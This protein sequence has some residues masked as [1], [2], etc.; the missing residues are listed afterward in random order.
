MY[1]YLYC[2]VLV[3]AIICIGFEVA[4]V[5]TAYSD[6]T[7]MEIKPI[8]AIYDG[9]NGFAL[10]DGAEDIVVYEMGNRTYAFV[11]SWN[12][13]G[14][15]IID[16]TNPAAPTAVAAISDGVNGFTELNDARNIV[17]SEIGNR[18]YAFVS[19]FNDDGVQIIDVT[20][21]A[22]PTAVAAIS[23]G[24]NGFTEL[25]GASDLTISEIGNRTYALVTGRNDD[26]VQII[27]VTNPA[28]PT[29]VAAISDGVNGFTELNG[30]ID[31]VISVIGNTTYAFVASSHGDGVQIIDVTNPAAPTAVAA[32]S[33]GVNGFTEL[34]AVTDIV[35]YE[36]GNHTYA[37]VTSWDDDGVQII[38]VTN[39]AAPTAVAAIS[40][41]VNGFTELDASAGITV[42]PIGN[43]TYAFVTGF[44]DDGVQIIDV[45]NP[46]APTAVAAIS[47]GVN[48]FTELDGATDITL[49][50]IGNRTYAFVACWESAS[51]Q[52]IDVTNPA[53]PVLT[54][55]VS[56]NTGGFAALDAANGVA[57]T[58]IH[59]HTYAVVASYS[60]DGVQIINITNP[61]S[62]T[63]TA[64]VTDNVG[65]FTE[66]D[67]AHEVAITKMSDQTYAIVASWD[68]DGVQIINI[69]NPAS[70]TPTAAVTDNVGGFTELDGA[71]ALAIAKMSDQTYAIVAGA[72]DDGIQIINITNPASP[73]PTAAVTDNVGGFSE[74]DAANGVAVANVAG[75]TYAVVVSHHDDGVQIINITN[76]ASP[77]P[78]AAVTDNVGGFTELDGAEGVAVVELS[79]R[80]YAIVASAGDDGV[81][82]I[83]ITN[84]ASPTPTAAVT[85]NVNG[86]VEL[87]VARNVAVIVI[88]GHTYALVASSHDD[89]VQVLDIT[90]PES[91]IPAASVTDNIDGFT[92][93]DGAVYVSIAEVSGK[94]YA[95]VTS[96]IDDGV[97]I[98][99]LEQKQTS[100]KPTLTTISNQTIPE[101]SK[102][103][104]NITATDA[105]TPANNLTY[106]ITNPPSGVTIHNTTGVLTWTPTESQ[107][108]IHSINV[109]VSDGTYSDS[110]TFTI[111]VREV[112]TS[113]VLNTIYNQ[114][115]P[116]LSKFT[117][118]ITA[119]DTD[120]PAN[121]LTYGITNPPSG[122]TIHNTTGTL[123]WTPT[124]SQ[125]GIHHI[126]VTVYDGARSDSQ[127][128]TV[129]VNSVVPTND[130]FSVGLEGWRFHQI[131]NTAANTLYCDT[132]N[133]DVY[134]LSHSSEHGGSVL[135][136]YTDTCWFGN[137][138][139][140]KTF[141]LPYNHNS[142]DEMSLNLDYRSAALN[143]RTGVGHVNNMH[144][145]IYDSSGNKI[146]GASIF[147]GEKS[148]GLRDTGW[149]SYNTTVSTISASQ[150]PCTIFIFTSDSWSTEWNQSIYFDNIA[151]TSSSSQSPPILN[152]IYNQTIPELS[153]FTLNITATDADT[154][155]NN[156]TYSITNPPSGVAIHNTTGVL[157]WTP[158]ESQNGIHHINVTVSDGTA[159][160]SQ[161]FT[162]TVREVNTAPVLATISNHTAPELSS[163][164]L[165]ITATDTDIPANNLTY[166]ITNPPS[167]VA[168]HN[169]TGVL[170]WTPAESQNG[171]HHI[172]VTVSDGTAADSQLFTITVREVNT[173][174]TLNTIPNHTIYV[175]SIFRLNITATDT[176]VPTNTLTYG[177]TPLLTGISINTHTGVFTWLPSESQIGTY[178][179]NATVSDGTSIDSQIFTVTVRDANSPPV[180][181]T[182]S[183]QTMQELS[184][185]ALNITATDADIPTD[186][187]SYSATN[188]PTGASIN[189][190]TGILTWTPTESQ[191]G[192]YTIQVTVSDGTSTDSQ[193]F[194]ITVQEVNSPPILTTI[195][196]QTIQELSKLILNITATDADV[197]TDTL[198]YSATNLPTGA[199]INA[200]TGTLTWTPTESQDGRYTIQV[201]VSDGTSTDSQSF[202]ITVQ[203]VNSPPILTTISNQTIQELSKLILN[204]TA[205]DA[206]VPTDTL[207][208]SA[209]NLPTGASINASTGTLTWTPTE[210]QD[211]R[212]TI[213]VTVSDGTSTDSQSFTITVQEVN[214]PPIL[215]LTPNQTI[216]ELSK[217]TL[218]IT[219]TDTDIPANTLTYGGINLPTGASININTGTFT[220]TPAESQDGAHK[221]QITVS[222]GTATFYRPLIITVQEVN[223]PPVL[224]TISNQTIQKL[225]TFTLNITATD[226][227]IPTNTLSY[228]ATNLPT[229]ASINASTGT[230]TWTPAESQDGTHTIQVTVSDGTATASQSFTITVRD[231][232]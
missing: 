159:A 22:A 74:L 207:S 168:I 24:V 37:F 229:G 70:P 175:Q 77:T 26:G 219:A 122:A 165:N 19:G 127:S 201:T 211:G 183:N 163:F 6:T 107:N 94:T 15:Q 172:N 71:E 13:D 222:D 134:S 30:A 192:R 182:I 14:V 179:F 7:T 48:G 80:T 101:L 27:D 167:G 8:T 121:N 170:T 228:S 113:P 10:L 44:Y 59:G 161:L 42:S 220:W 69:T 63:P 83:N 193:S 144:Y 130:A 96:V 135:V 18:T 88:S 221:F 141:T 93:L 90:D 224:N 226:T 149:K 145:A 208:Y 166:S 194:T 186:T 197:P 156:L 52:I 40:D 106:S 146:Q 232:N 215:Y 53:A 223:S 120:I 58:K 142:G 84:P 76:P 99:E 147:Q 225:S 191:D 95:L 180:L 23:D 62:P 103:T 82:I 187:L 126:N 66:L 158:A 51:I 181:N 81:Q 41:G 100:S 124:E 33:D 55:T 160:D 105:D 196:N 36:I 86:F 46:A 210:S 173:P 114:T 21:P 98:M 205:T 125:N 28:A 38:D 152:T 5:D 171:I 45:T 61:A 1:A 136:N 227:D 185:L 56:D 190:S 50:V 206:D 216:Q 104:L 29:A 178:R 150:C 213:Q 209:T 20:N 184:K 133:T 17:V 162:I 25:D 188:L 115:I 67:G 112:N 4:I 32:I 102:F 148:S 110:K 151:I 72:V 214:S 137:A 65:G 9:M 218:N 34:D 155:A 132:Q 3:L 157:T 85:D 129:T 139:A 87:D 143:V 117:L 118:N 75:K 78:T 43:H 198:S 116:E 200:S 123:T 189:A 111:T 140:I 31:I 119:T 60:D 16:V 154:P 109:T 177:L 97:Q 49:H 169:T 64:A 164:T 212:Y 199:S 217:F 47:D 202:T 89:G 204:I 131:P 39:P 57:V 2:I 92:G 153:K 73:T 174:P 176:D 54:K 68:D 203:E 231:T 91:P 35:L 108:G 79:G 11:A 128:F 12:D 230:L 195:S 138:G